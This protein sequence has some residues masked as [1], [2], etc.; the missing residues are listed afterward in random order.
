MS[1]PKELTSKCTFSEMIK[2]NYLYVDKTQH[3]HHLFKGGMNYY[4]FSRPRRFGKS[5]LISTLKELFAGSKKLFEGLWI[6]QSDWEWKQHPVI[7]LDFSE[8]AHRTPEALERSL[9]KHLKLHAQ[10]Y[11]IVLD[12]ED[13]I[14]DKFYSLV[15]ELAKKEKVVI[16]IDEYDKPIIDHI[17]NLKIAERN[18]EVLKGFYDVLKGL[19]ADLRAIFVTGV[20]KFA[21]TSLFSGI[22][23]L[24]DISQK[25][26][27]AALLGY[28]QQELEHYLTPYI[29]EMATK[30]KTSKQEILNEM[31]QWYNGY[32]FGEEEVRVYNPFS[33]LYYLKDKKRDNYWIKSG[34][35]TFLIQLL[36]KNYQVLRDFSGVEVGGATFN[37]IELTA[38]IPLIPLLYQTGYLTIRDVFKEFD[39]MGKNP[40]LKY[41]LDYPNQEVREAFLEYML[42]ALTL[43]DEV[44]LAAVIDGIRDALDSNNIEAL[45]KQ[46]SIL[47]ANLPS[48]LHISREAYYHS[49][50]ALTLLFMGIKAQVEEPTDKG[51][52]D[53]VIPTLR[54]IF[55]IELKLNRPVKEAFDQINRKKYYQKYMGQGVPITLAGIA[56]N[57]K[58]KE[59]KV[60]YVQEVLD[61][62]K[63][64]KK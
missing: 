10:K 19:D 55:V 16:L 13:S 51:Y 24:D 17:S 29:A 4:F 20:S 59:L 42:I 58:K 25:P 15:T 38:N 14:E 41:R 60:A 45:C 7:H 5:L 52:I 48:K 50:L 34:T 33:V 49:I 37:P 44:S 27:A 61:Q 8:I 43:S 57:Y 40:K 31:K 35:P 32:R 21:Q 2:Q 62:H 53:L 23:H 64:I 28:T 22:N 39:L 30:H 36:K 54:R 3:M 46:L 6:E 9:N 11:N 26:E 18:R 12:P 56:F 1:K 47:F 63:E